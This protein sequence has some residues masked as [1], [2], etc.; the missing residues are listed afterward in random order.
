MVYLGPS[1][2]LGVGT[3]WQ[4]IKS[5]GYELKRRPPSEKNLKEDMAKT[6][7]SGTWTSCSGTTPASF[8]V[9][10][11]AAIVLSRLTNASGNLASEL[12]RAKKVDLTVKRWRTVELEGDAFRDWVNTLPDNNG[13]KQS[14]GKQN[15][16]VAYRAIEVEEMSATLT[17]DEADAVNVQGKFGPGEKEIDEGSA[18]LK[19]EFKGGKSLVITSP[20][21]FVI[22]AELGKYTPAPANAK[23]SSFTPLKPPEKEAAVR[24]DLDK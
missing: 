17:F 4:P 21:P 5:G 10:S 2:D 24:E 1:N 7:H 16:V 18:K 14:L 3:I 15:R 13:Y 12:K 22:E 8:G 19:A 6:I 23:G 20:G 9:E 11:G